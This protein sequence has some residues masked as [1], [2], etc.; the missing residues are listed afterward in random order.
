MALAYMGMYSFNSFPFR[1]CLGN[2]RLAAV[3]FE[4]KLKHSNDIIE[5]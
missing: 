2:L 4:N 5:I 1:E 3:S